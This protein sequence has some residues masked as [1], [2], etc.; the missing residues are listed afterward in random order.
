MNKAEFQRAFA[1][2]ISKEDLSKFD[3]TVLDGF[4]L[5]DF[6]PVTVP[7]QSVAK[8]IRWQAIQ[9]NGGIDNEALSLCRDRFRHKVTVVW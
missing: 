7:I 4:G 9:L 8:M 2:A 6:V 3:D 1:I 5:P